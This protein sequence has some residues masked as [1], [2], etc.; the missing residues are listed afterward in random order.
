MKDKSFTINEAEKLMKVLDLEKNLELSLNRGE[1]DI[2]D[3]RVQTIEEL[4][5]KYS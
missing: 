2:K 4:E 3:G 5:L 1:E